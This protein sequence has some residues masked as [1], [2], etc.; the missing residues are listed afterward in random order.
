MYVQVTI[1]AQ[2]T[3][4]GVWLTMDWDLGIK[5][6]LEINKPM[7]QNQRERGGIIFKIKYDL[8]NLYQFQS[9]QLHQPTPSPLESPT[10][11]AIRLS[12]PPPAPYYSHCN[13]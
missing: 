4:S 3:L 9:L 6:V 11:I 12:H 10:T 7:P 13:S 8:H 5:Y 1:M 2:K